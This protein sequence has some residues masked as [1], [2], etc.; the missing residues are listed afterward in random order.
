MRELLHVTIGPTRPLE[1]AGPLGLAWAA[2]DKT[3]GRAW[4]FQHGHPH[5]QDLLSA[6]ELLTGEPV[7][8]V[9]VARREVEALL[10]D[11]VGY[12]ELGLDADHPDPPGLEQ[13]AA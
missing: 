10:A 1:R 2:W 6:C 13:L 9:D 3:H 8:R 5:G 11:G 4:R 12:D 7:G